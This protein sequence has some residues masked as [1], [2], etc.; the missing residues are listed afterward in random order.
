MMAMAFYF[1]YV[2]RYF[3]SYNMFYFLALVFCAYGVRGRKIV[4]T[5]LLET[6]LL[7]LITVMICAMGDID[8]LRYRREGLVRQSLG[9]IYPTDFAAHLTFLAILFGVYKNDHYRVRDGLAIMCMAVFAYYV[10]N[11]RLDS[12]VIALSVVLFMLNAFT[13]HSKWLR[14][15]V[16]NLA[17][18]ALSIGYPILLIGTFYLSIAWQNG[19]QFA[20]KINHLLSSRISLV[21]EAL[22]RYT[23]NWF[24]QYVS[25]SGY[26]GVAGKNMDRTIYGYFMIDSSMAQLVIMY[27]IVM[28][29]ITSI[30]V[31]VIIFRTGRK[32]YL[33]LQIGLGLVL[34]HAFVAQFL[35]NPG[36][37]CILFLAFANLNYGFDTAFH[38]RPEYDDLDQ[39]QPNGLLQ[40]IC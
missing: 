18:V 17:T 35:F 4:G 20:D 27:G 34:L 32:H 22:T 36:Y 39:L 15:N 19:S 38:E 13:F 10:C 2:I 37:D 30:I 9:F 21:A 16:S 25:M 40:A 28:A 31:Y 7:V 12:I 33:A 11:A 26:G 23:I 29:I 14:K 24:G 8:N 3:S 5:A 6:I 1:A